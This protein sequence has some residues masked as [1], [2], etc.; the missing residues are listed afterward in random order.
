[1]RLDRF[2]EKAQEA[3]QT[4]AREAQERGQQ[5]VEPDHLLLA[6]VRQ[7]DGIARPLLEA[8]GVSIPAVQA[9]LVS[10]VE[11]LPRVQG[12]AQAYLG[13]DLARALEAAEREA[14][15]L[16]DEYVSTEHL[17]L[18]LADHPVLKEAGV[19]RDGLM[20]ALR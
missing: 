8:A 10:R 1:M 17:L 9:A 12:G 7:E 6:L 20:Q 3:L 14:E 11:R 19:T 13:Q 2:T 15:Q 4:A 16:K 5:T 18:A